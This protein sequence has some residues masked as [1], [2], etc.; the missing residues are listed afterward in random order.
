MLDTDGILAFAAYTLAF[1][2]PKLQDPIRQR[3][4]VYVWTGISIL[5]MG[6][7]MNLFSM[8]QGGCELSIPQ[9]AV[10]ANAD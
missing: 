6:V 8:K 5:M 4:G 3:F 7:L 9:I 1:T 10:V 2:I